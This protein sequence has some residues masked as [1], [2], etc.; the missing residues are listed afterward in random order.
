MTA[1][2]VRRMD[3]LISRWT[4]LGVILREVFSLSGTAA[5]ED[6]GAQDETTAEIDRCYDALASLAEEW[7]P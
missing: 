4:D 7:K 6:A 5:M 1:I 3:L 2:T